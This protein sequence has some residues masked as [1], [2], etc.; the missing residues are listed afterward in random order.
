MSEREPA[1]TRKR[2]KIKVAVQCGVIRDGAVDEGRVNGG[3]KIE[4]LVVGIIRMN[5]EAR[6][7]PGRW[8]PAIPRHREGFREVGIDCA[9]VVVKPRRRRTVDEVG[10][11]GK[12]M[13]M[14]ETLHDEARNRLLMY[15]YHVVVNLDVK[16]IR[17]G[18][19]ALPDALV[20]ALLAV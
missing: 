20:A 4:G 3:T 1:V 8:T 11:D 10:T 5:G 2:G 17:V 6:G 19:E 7:A 13:G 15:I 12:G 16:R 9:R 18:G 14:F